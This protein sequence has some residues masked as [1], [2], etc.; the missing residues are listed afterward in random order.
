MIGIPGVE[1]SVSVIK[2]SDE[3]AQVIVV[4][5]KSQAFTNMVC[6][7]NMPAVDGQSASNLTSSV[8][9]DDHAQAA[10]QSENANQNEEIQNETSD[11]AKL[12]GEKIC[13]KTALKQLFFSFSIDVSLTLEYQK[14]LRLLMET[15]QK[16]SKLIN[17]LILSDN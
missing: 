15:E 17:G 5:P 10:G 14:N 1:L 11:L 8:L 6:I 13:K 3:S 7:M 12:I 16:I 9:I 2:L 4:D